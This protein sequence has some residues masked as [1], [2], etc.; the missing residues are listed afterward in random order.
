MSISSVLHWCFGAQQ[1]VGRDHGRS[2]GTDSPD[3]AERCSPQ[4]ERRALLGELQRQAYLHELLRLTCADVMRTPPVTVSVDE[5]IGGALKTLDAHHIKLLPVVDTHG[6]LKGVVTHVDL[7]PLDEV[8]PFLKL[9]SDTT[10]PESERR[11]WP[12][13][14]VMSAHVRYVDVL[15]PLTE[16]IPLFTTNGHH[17]LPVVEEGGRVVGMLTQADILKLMCGRPGGI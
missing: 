16:I 2:D 10:A 15:T 1:H 8:L 4:D 3:D 5:T 11:E 9:A 13:T 17:H 7:Q 6:R 14:T 12:V